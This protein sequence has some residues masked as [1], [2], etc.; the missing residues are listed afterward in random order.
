MLLRY[1]VVPVAAPAAAPIAAPAAASA[2]APAVVWVRPDDESA[3]GW[4]LSNGSSCPEMSSDEVRPLAAIGEKIGCATA[5]DLQDTQPPM[6]AQPPKLAEVTLPSGAKSMLVERDKANHAFE[7]KLRSVEKLLVDM[8]VRGELDDL[9]VLEGG[10]GPSW[11][12]LNETTQPSAR[13]CHLGILYGAAETIDDDAA[14]VYDRKT[15]SA[16]EVSVRYRLP[17]Y[18]IAFSQL[19]YWPARPMPKLIFELGAMAWRIVYALLPMGSVS[20]QCPPN[21]LVAMYYL[22]RIGAKINLHKDGTLGG[23]GA[24][25]N[26]HLP[27]SVVI[28]V[29]LGDTPM[30]V[31]PAPSCRAEL[32][33]KLPCHIAC[34]LPRCS[35]CSHAWQ[36]F[37]TSQNDGTIK[38]GHRIVL[39]WGTIWVLHPG[40]DSRFFHVRPRSL[41]LRS[42]PC[43]EYAM[44]RCSLLSRSSSG[45]VVCPWRPQRWL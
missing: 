40:D 28:V 7:D 39:S 44:L 29:T 25:K 2:A 42:A 8:K 14:F 11:V 33:A 27:G 26:S 20:R 38:W 18:S 31:R 1:V 10:C 45:C 43:A 41:E 23:G 3:A 19:R 16:K 35:P 13:R 15:K 32:P 12:A 34:C 37:L 24:S 17:C 30:D 5:A 6:E 9:Q 4:R 22:N 36:L 21:A